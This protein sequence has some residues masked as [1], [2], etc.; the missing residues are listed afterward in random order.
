MKVLYGDH[1]R[2]FGG[3]YALSDSG[4]AFRPNTNENFWQ[5]R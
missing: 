1:G 2:S 3:Q 5:K 4:K